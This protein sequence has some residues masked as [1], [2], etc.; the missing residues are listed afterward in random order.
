MTA[1]FACNKGLLERR[2]IHRDPARVDRPQRREADGTFVAVTWD[3]ALDDIAARLRAIVDEHGPSAVAMYLGNPTAFNATAGPA[4]GV[5]L[6][7]LG[8]DR[9]FTAG[10]QDCANKFA[11]GELLWGSA[12]IHLIPDLDHTD[13][14][15]LLGTN[16]RVSK[17]S[18]L[19]VPD[20][21]GRLAEIEAR[22]GRGALRRPPPLRAA[23]SARRSRSSPTPTSTCSPPCS[24]RSTA[25]SGSTQAGRPGC[26]TSTRSAP[27]S[28]GFPPERVADVV[29][30]DAA[31]IIAMAAGVRGG[32]AGVGPLLDRGEHG[33][34]RRPRLLAAAHAGAAHR[35]L[36]PPGR[37]HP[38]RPGHLPRAALRATPARTASSTRPGGP[39]AP[40]PAGCPALC[41]AP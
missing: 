4:A 19:S 1:G 30:L 14:L 23:R 21:V 24:A 31:T 33:S 37:Q 16:P 11:I 26:G 3:D 39:T 17:G 9:I 20:P 18:F 38:R 40:A 35:Q 5:F 41:W 15:L 2:T 8:S 10:S 32:G 6:L 12:Q 22:G 25:P 34:P 13:H 36:R 28:R 27:S 29:G 7:Q